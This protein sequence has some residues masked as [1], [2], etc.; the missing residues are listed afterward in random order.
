M[1]TVDAKLSANRKY[2]V[3]GAC[4]RSLCRRDRVDEGDAIR[5]ELTNPTRPVMDDEWLRQQS[6]AIRRER[7]EGPLPWTLSPAELRKVE[8][9]MPSL[10]RVHFELVWDGD[11]YP[12]GDHIERGSSA[13]D[14][15]A[16]GSAPIRRD[17]Q[18]RFRG[19]G[20]DG[21][22]DKQN[23][24]DPRGSARSALCPWAV[25]GAM[26]RMDPK[27]LRVWDGEDGP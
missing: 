19:P 18:R 27:R 25:C 11:W 15:L 22:S 16:R 24:L 2:A 4:G 20:D 13:L 3:C 5:R 21:H 6:D 17:F 23:R 8:M 12:V 26:N 14:R 10:F 9:E 7:T 1:T